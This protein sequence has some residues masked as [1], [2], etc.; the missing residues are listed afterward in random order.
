MSRA[1]PAAGVDLAGPAAG[2]PRLD[3]A[4]ARRAAPAATF[5]LPFLAV[6]LAFLLYPLGRGLW[7]SL[8]DWE[9][10]GGS[11]GWV[12]LG[13]YRELADDPMLWTTLGN[14]LRFVALAVPATTLLALALALALVRP[15]PFYAALRAVFFF[16]SVLSVTIVTL[17]WQIFLSPD[18]GLVGSVF[19]SLGLRPIGFLSE[20]AWAMPAIVLTSVWWGIGLPMMIFIAGLQQIPRELYEAARLDRAPRWKVLWCITLPALKRTTVLVLVTQIVIHFQV[21]GQ[22][23]LMT[24]G[25]PADSTRSLVQYIYE[26]GFRDWRLGYG[27]AVAMVLFLFM[28]AASMLQLLLMRE[29]RR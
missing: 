17:V 26:S 4:G 23:L 21:F 25:G 5:L 19:E 12:G 11:L 27:S 3:L 28:F 7:I 14:T 8:H 15:G 18:R 9:L 20:V 16:S 1:A 13:N 29:E 24:R 2:R 22:P 6:Y 10:I